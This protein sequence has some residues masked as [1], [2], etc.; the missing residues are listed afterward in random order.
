M[1]VLKAALLWQHY[2]DNY[3]IK[4]AM[5]VPPKVFFLDIDT[6]SSLTWVQSDYINGSMRLVSKLFDLDLLALHF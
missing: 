3:Y 4:M 6:G 1:G 2:S 5:G